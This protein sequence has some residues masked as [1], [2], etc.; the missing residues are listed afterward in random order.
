MP[1]PVDDGGELADQDGEAGGILSE[2][3]L[4]R[5]Y[6]GVNTININQ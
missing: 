1:E 3:E 4:L 2:T 6:E 5:M